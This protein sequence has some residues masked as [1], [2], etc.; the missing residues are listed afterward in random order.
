MKFPIPLLALPFLV[1]AAFA[2]VSFNG[3]YTQNFDSLI[4]SGPGTFTDNTT[5]TGWYRANGSG[6]PDTSRQTLRAIGQA[7]D[8]T[9]GLTSLGSGNATDRALGCRATTAIGTVYFGVRLT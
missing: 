6:S 5:L 4:T 8:G 7:A 2:Q 9:L 1:S 3:V